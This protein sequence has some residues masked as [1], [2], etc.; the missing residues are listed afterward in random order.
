MVVPDARSIL[1]GAG[2]AAA[3]MGLAG[4]SGGLVWLV[5]GVWTARAMR[6]QPLSVG[7][8]LAVLGAGLR[9]GT[10]G[11]VD[12]GVATKLLAPT[13]VAGGLALRLCMGAAVAAALISEAQILSSSDG[14]WLDKAVTA[15]ALTALG[16]LFALQ[17]SINLPTAAAAWAGAALVGTAIVLALRPLAGRTPT[18]IPAV[19]ALAAILATGIAR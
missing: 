13:I 8:G 16:P 3:I 2:L 17:G 15:V 19:A 1:V 18:W 5:A 10:T 12:V 11:L 4:V 14:S 9:W 6:S 7:W